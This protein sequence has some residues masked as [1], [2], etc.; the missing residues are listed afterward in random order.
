MNAVN[1]ADIRLGTKIS[2]EAAS[3]SRVHQRIWSMPSI[4]GSACGRGSNAAVRTR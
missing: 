2:V 3:S 4:A 1:H